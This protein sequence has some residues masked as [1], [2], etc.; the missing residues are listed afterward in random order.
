MK[1]LA[2][3]VEILQVYTIVEVE[4]NLRP[5]VSWPVR[6]G[7]RHPSE[8]H[9]Q[10]LFLLQTYACLLFCSALSDERTGL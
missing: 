1:I 8:T 2:S 6:L 9:D 3:S 7:V 4:V 10:F 5:T